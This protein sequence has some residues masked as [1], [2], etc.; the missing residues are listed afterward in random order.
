MQRGEPWEE[1]VEWDEE[2]VEHG[3]ADV[4]LELDA[5]RAQH[6]RAAV[7]RQVRGDLEQH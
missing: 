1:I 6:A 4:G 7:G 2:P 5:F 3:V